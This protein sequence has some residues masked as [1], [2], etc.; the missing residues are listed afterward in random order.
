MSLNKL[1]YIVIFALV[2]LV[3]FLLFFNKS[4]NK[5]LDW[6]ENYNKNSKQPYGTYLVYEIAK[7]HYIDHDFNIIKS[8]ISDNLN[9][10]EIYNSNYI[11]IGKHL[12]LDSISTNTLLD[13]AENGNNVFISAK[14]F[15]PHLIKALIKTVQN[16]STD[17]SE[18]G[19]IGYFTTYAPVYLNLLHPDLKL[20]Q[21]I[22]FQFLQDGKADTY[23]WSY[24]NDDIFCDYNVKVSS[25]KILKIG[26]IDN[27]TN[28]IKIKYGKGNFYLHTTPQAFTNLHMNELYGLTYFEQVFAHLNKGDI[29]WD[30]YSH[31]SSS[32]N[33]TNKND[34]YFEPVS[35]SENSP[36]EYIL[37]Q[38]PLRWAWYLLILLGFLFLLFRTKRRQRVIPIQ[39]QNSNTSL[40]FIESIGQLYFQMN[41]HQKLEEQKMKL[42]LRFVRE[43][44]K[45]AVH[46]IDG[47]FIRNLSIVSSIPETKV[48]AIF[49]LYNGHSKKTSIYAEQLIN[50]HQ[51][52]DY[53]YRNC[54]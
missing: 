41:D 32:S 53:F 50:F 23:S 31:S 18:L 39:E 11:F 7:R 3:L 34:K 14:D 46:N 38:K 1:K 20:S 29:Y 49:A 12:L 21:N 52:M 25:E 10:S 15:S 17:F 4:K 43:R 8:K 27:M 16:C 13:F 54:K 37:S 33:S 42:F 6:Y 48:K 28:F 5:Q 24:F 22:E 47:D 40:E 51:A 36:I 2:I 44:Y 26:I 19:I 45:I 30:T 9:S 35:L